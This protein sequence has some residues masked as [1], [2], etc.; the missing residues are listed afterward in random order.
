VRSIRLQDPFKL[1]TLWS[2][3]PKAP[4]GSK[5]RPV[6]LTNIANT[7]YLNSLLQVGHVS[8]SF[9]NGRQILNLDPQQYFFTVRDLRE[10]ILQFG[11]NMEIPE[12]EQANRV[13]GRLVTKAEVERSR[14]CSS[15]SPLIR[16]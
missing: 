12:G 14:R 13:G 16:E 15:L 7:C 1:L 3:P 4:E 9:A 2:A 8:R 6:G 10:T 5:D 11:S